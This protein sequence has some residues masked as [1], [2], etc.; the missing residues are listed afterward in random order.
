MP[1]EDASLGEAAQRAKEEKAKQKAIKAAEKRYLDELMQLDLATKAAEKQYM[2]DL[3][4]RESAVESWEN[5]GP[6]HTS[7]RHK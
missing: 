7:P 6:S 4:K 2:E 5:R 3:R 1:L